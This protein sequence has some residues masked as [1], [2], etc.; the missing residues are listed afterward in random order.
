MV[1]RESMKLESHW[2]TTHFLLGPGFIDF[3]GILG[4]FTNLLAGKL[5]L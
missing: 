1:G 2:E 3:F 4:G 5:K